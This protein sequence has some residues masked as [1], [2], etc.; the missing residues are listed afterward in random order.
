MDL[1]TVLALETGSNPAT[2]SDIGH[3]PDLGEHVA[4]NHD[5]RSENDDH[6]PCPAILEDGSSETE[7]KRSERARMDVRAIRVVSMGSR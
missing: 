2:R 1:L 7:D 5:E 6:G 4:G 3:A